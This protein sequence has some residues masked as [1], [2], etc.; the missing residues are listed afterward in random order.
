MPCKQP[1]YQRAEG[2]LLEVS[3]ICSWCGVNVPTRAQQ[4]IHT[5]WHR[6]VGVVPLH[7]LSKSDPL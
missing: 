3:T 2:E 6:A 7:A 1:V 4:V 5:D